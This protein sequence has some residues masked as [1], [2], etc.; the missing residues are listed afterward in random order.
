MEIK[1]GFPSYLY[2]P[3]YRYSSIHSVIPS[4]G[5]MRSAPGNYNCNIEPGSS[6]LRIDFL[7]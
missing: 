7:L 2:F 5:W 6:W 4:N 1:F 3:T